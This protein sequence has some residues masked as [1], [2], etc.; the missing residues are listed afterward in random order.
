[1][2]K[3]TKDDAS[4]LLQLMAVMAADEDNK[5]ASNWIFEKFNEKNYDDFKAK[6][7]M[8]SEGYRN[9]MTFASNG[10]LLGTLVN[11]ELLS[12]DLVFDL[13]GSMLWE[14]IEPI[15]HGMRKDLEMPR[16]YENFE[17]CAKKYPMWTEKNPPKV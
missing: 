11:K 13:Y 9:F 2:S 7:P 15:V 1:M 3:P 8:G 17:V 12:E 5:K 10:E 14:K 6:Y 16:L 4:L